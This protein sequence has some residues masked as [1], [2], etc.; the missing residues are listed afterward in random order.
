[1]G[2]TTAKRPRR[3]QSSWRFTHSLGRRASFIC[4]VQG[5]PFLSKTRIKEAY[6]YFVKQLVDYTKDQLERLFKTVTSRLV[7]VSIVLES[8]DDAYLIFEGLNAKGLPLTQADLI[9]NYLLMRIHRKRQD[10]VYGTYW[11]PMQTAFEEHL[12]EFI[13]HFLMRHGTFVKKNEVYATMK[14]NTEGF[15]EAE[16]TTYL[17]TLHRFSSYYLKLTKPETEP[18]PILWKWLVSLKR[19]DITT[20]YPFLLDLFDEL[21]SGKVSEES[22]VGILKLL[23]TFLVRRFVC[24]VPTHDLN[25]FFPTLLLQA[26]QSQNLVK[27]VADA[28]AKRLFPKTPE[29]KREFFQMKMY[30]SGER[31]VKAKLILER[32]E[33]SYEHKEE[34]N[35]EDLSIEHI[36]PQTPNDWWKS[37][38][39]ENWE[40]IHE[41]YVHTIG[42][43]T[44]TG[45]NP[46]LS[47]SAFPVKVRIYS[48]SHLELTKSIGG[49]KWTEKEITERMEKLFERANGVWPYFGKAADEEIE[50]GPEEPSPVSGLDPVMTAEELVKLL[51]G[52]KSIDGSR[53]CFLLNDGR[54]IVVSVSREYDRGRPFWYG[55]S[56]NAIKALDNCTHI[57]LGMGLDR[58]ALL[59]AE[60]MKD[61]VKHCGDSKYKTGS[62]HHYHVF[63]SN[64][65][66]PE[67]YGKQDSP[68][69]ELSRFI[70]G[71]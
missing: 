55:I 60:L 58:V 46:D 49:D 61:Y 26:K 41:R 28:L 31:T 39:G 45:Y 48:E 14:A 22:F 32:L 62:I 57:A 69:V 35:T 42:N 40:N 63:I 7:F 20:A 29:F 54:Q 21:A 33:E 38:L 59:P 8:D 19:L 52:G 5:K 67:M 13:R 64:G 36:M 43:L 53:S 34:V 12:T 24:S 3:P 16:T 25:K 1:M 37:H 70:V 51:G 11:M 71:G 6:F 50:E 30:G 65:D 18:N 47:N 66:K 10:S 17:E 56:P 44:L 68:R 2:K 15:A 4:L 27:G 23:E 9:R